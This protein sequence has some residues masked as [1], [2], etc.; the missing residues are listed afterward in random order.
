[1]K[2]SPGRDDFVY[3]LLDETEQQRMAAALAGL[4]SAQQQKLLSLL[5]RVKVQT[6]RGWLT[7]G[8]L[9]E[10]VKQGLHIQSEKGEPQATAFFALT[11]ALLPVF[12]SG[13]IGEWVRLGLELEGAD[14]PGVFMT[15]PTGFTELGETERLNFY[16]LIRTVAYRA[17]PVAAAL[18]RSLPPGIQALPRAQ[19]ELLLRCLQA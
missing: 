3:S 13:E 8:L 4:G 7:S 19:R 10:W 12:T 15:L 6:V 2:D 5:T 18:Y 16:R 9:G 11:A 1:M 17:A 14:E